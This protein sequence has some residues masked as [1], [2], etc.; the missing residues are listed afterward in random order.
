MAF[1]L[2]GGEHKLPPSPSLPVCCSLSREREMLLPEA[3]AIKLDTEKRIFYYL[4]INL[5]L[6]G[7]LA[8][9]LPWLQPL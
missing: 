9:L 3:R 7:G 1:A 2:K 5:H 8:R 4:G 6:L